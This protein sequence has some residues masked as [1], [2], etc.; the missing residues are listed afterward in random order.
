LHHP[1]GEYFGKEPLKYVYVDRVIYCNP[2]D[3]YSSERSRLFLLGYTIKPFN[4]YK[5]DFPGAVPTDNFL[6][7]DSINATKNN[8]SPRA[9]AQA[10][11]TS[12]ATIQFS[13][14]VSFTG[15]K[16]SAERFFV[17]QDD[18]LIEIQEDTYKQL[19][20]NNTPNVK[21]VAPQKY[22]VIGE[23]DDS[24]LRTVLC[25]IQPESDRTIYIKKN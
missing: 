13:G 6:P 18:K 1:K 4:E 16:I 8:S 10:S 24:Y 23:T 15:Q 5:I 11:S 14:V 21:I 2:D 19:V 25:Q 12:V 20:K 3:M 9:N 7:E 17:V 22:A